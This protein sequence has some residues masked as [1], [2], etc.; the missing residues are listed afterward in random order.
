MARLGTS[1]VARVA[2][3]HLKIPLRTTFVQSHNVRSESDNLI[4]E[5]ELG[6]GTV[7]FGEGVPRSYVTGETPEDSWEV[8]RSVEGI[9]GRFQPADDLLSDFVAIER[10]VGSI[11]DAGTTVRN[12]TRAAVEIALLDCTAR[13][14]RQPLFGAL[15]RFLGT[16][17][18]RVATHSV[19]LGRRQADDLEFLADVQRRYG[20]RAA[21]VKVGFGLEEDLRLVKRVRTGL[22][23][24]VE[25]RVDANRSWSVEDAAEELVRLAEQGVVAAEDPLR[26]DDLGTLAAKLETLRKATGMTIVLDEPVRTLGELEFL[27]ERGVV[28]AVSIRVS[29]C[30]GLI[31][32]GRMAAFCQQRGILVQVGCQAGETA[33]LSAAGRLLAHSIGDVRFLEGSNEHLK[34]AVPDVISREDLNYAYGAESSVL[35]GAGLGLTIIGAQ[36]RRLAG[37]RIHET[38][39]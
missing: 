30:G 7:G 38:A 5:I 28:D 18:G 11:A 1:S 39:L 17:R 21:K 10:I 13:H 36:L 14:H 33:I 27:A 4:C 31:P 3:Y 20:F 22:G 8:L 35:A 15:E 37:P 32:A 9:I 29:K 25:L 6:D 2:V 23:P 19:V 26:A 16:R 24:D 12:A 34:W